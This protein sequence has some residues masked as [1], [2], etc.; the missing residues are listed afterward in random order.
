LAETLAFGTLLREGTPVRLSGQDS[1]RGTFSHRHSVWY[2]EQTGEEHVPANHIH[3]EQAR[4]CAHNSLLSEGAVLGFEYGYSLVGPEM[5]IIWEAQFGDF[6]NGAQVIIDQFIVSSQAKW[7][8]TSGLV[9]LLPHGYEGQGPEHSNAYLE[10]YLAAC[11][12]DN[13]QVCNLSTP[14]QYFHALRRQMRRPFR[15]PLVVMSPKSLLRHPAAVSPIDELVQG[16]FVS[17]LDDPS[18]PEHPRRLVLC[19]GKVFYD[20]LAQRDRT[21]T[22]TA[23]VRVE[24]LYPFPR[25]ELQSLAQRYEMVDE[26]VWAQEEPENRGAAR[27]LRPRLEREIFPGREVRYAGRAASASP[28]IGS[29]RVHKREQ[30]ALVAQAL[31]HSGDAPRKP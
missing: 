17:V 8:R 22:P 16:R 28:A 3:A 11:A 6:A 24:Q 27:Y 7:E 14:A 13:I 1:R 31:G 12:E 21:A 5:L 19:S 30:A 26:I 10:R 15:R 18:P 4:F 20:L 29:P 2:D 23:L 9:M 25:A